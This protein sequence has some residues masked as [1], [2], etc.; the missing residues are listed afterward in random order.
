MDSRY[1]VP[2]KK[3]LGTALA[4]LAIV[5]VVAAPALAQRDPFDPVIDLTVDTSGAGATGGNS[6][7]TTDAGTDGSGST[8]NPDAR[9]D[10]FPN[11]GADTTG[12]L[13]IAYVLLA[14]GIALVVFARTMRPTPTT[15][16]SAS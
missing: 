4:S 6:D 9:A 15:R 8:S 7:G 16:R 10:V 13:A 11:T 12:W 5:L 3:F 14:A 1:A 2:M